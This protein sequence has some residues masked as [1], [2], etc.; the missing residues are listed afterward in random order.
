MNFKVNLNMG[1]R[2]RLTNY[3]ISIL[4]ARHDK[5]NKKLM[6]ECGVSVGEFTLKL[7]DDGYYH[8]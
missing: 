8:T 4:K 2:V 3:G 1:V 5:L 6:D 7:D